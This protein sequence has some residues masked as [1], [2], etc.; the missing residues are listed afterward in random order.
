MQKQD[1]LVGVPLVPSL[2]LDS[3][4]EIPFPKVEREAR[5]SG[6]A[7]HAHLGAPAVDS[8]PAVGAD[9]VVDLKWRLRKGKDSCI[10]MDEVL[11]NGLFLLNSQS[12][13]HL[14]ND[15]ILLWYW[16]YGSKLHSASLSTASLWTVVLEA[17]LEAGSGFPLLEKGKGTNNQKAAD[18]PEAL[19]PLFL[20]CI[21]HEQPR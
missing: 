14:R 21:C 6:L 17:N 16:R 19:W 10:C 12:R 15:T 13:F 4:G 1:E 8:E 2:Q 18:D 5:Y 20:L 7:S 3:S 9:D 11:C